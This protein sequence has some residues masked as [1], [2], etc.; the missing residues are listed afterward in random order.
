MSITVTQ[1]PQYRL[2]YVDQVC[3]RLGRTPH[4]VRHLL[5]SGQIKSARLGGRR[6]VRESDLNAFIDAAFA[7]AD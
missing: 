2:L 7:E 3:E 1:E 5:H 4:A 6:V